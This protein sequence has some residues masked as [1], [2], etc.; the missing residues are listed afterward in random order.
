[1]LPIEIKRSCDTRARTALKTQLAD[2]YMTEAGTAIGV[3]VLAWFDA[4]N[5]AK[6]HRPKWS[7]IDEARADLDQ[8][9]QRLRK[10]EG[11][12]VRVAIVD[13]RLR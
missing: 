10:A 9:A 8:Q 13:L 7:A 11:I 12:D 3:Y 2:R 5:L 4:P 1:M 6:H